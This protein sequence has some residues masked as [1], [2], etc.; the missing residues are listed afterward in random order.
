L[1][2]PA[3][4]AVL[5]SSELEYRHPHSPFIGRALRGRVARTLLRGRTVAIDGRSVGEPRGRFVR[6]LLQHR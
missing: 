4:E 2:D 6:P 5:T 1:L 3:P